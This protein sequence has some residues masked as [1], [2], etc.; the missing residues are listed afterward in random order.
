MN[1]N[2]G[3][4]E[5]RRLHYKHL[6]K[7]LVSCSKFSRLKPKLIFEQRPIPLDTPTE[8]DLT[9]RRRVRVTLFHAN[10]CP[11]AVMFLIE[12]DGKA[13]IYSGDIRGEYTTC[14]H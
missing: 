11:G 9:P 3:I 1:F 14:L 5:S 2:K 12:G 13:I 6:A 4:L 7:L 8:I 10:H